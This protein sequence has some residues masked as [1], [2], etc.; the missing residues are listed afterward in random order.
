MD[1]STSFLA[2]AARFVVR[3]DSTGVRGGTG[4]FAAPGKVLT[5]AHVVSG[6]TGDSEETRTVSRVRVHWA[7][8]SS[9]G[10]VQARPTSHGGSGL[11]RYPDLAVITLLEPPRGHAWLPL[12]DALPAF[13]SGM[14]VAGFSSV[15]ERGTPQLSGTTLQFESPHMFDGHDMLKVKGGELAPGISGGP[16]LDLALGRVV[17]LVTTTRK[18]GWDMGGLALPVSAVRDCFPALWEEN[19]HPDRPDEP[20]QDLLAALRHDS[21]A[22]L[23]L[24][25]WEERKLVS[26]AEYLGMDPNALYWQAVGGLGR[27]PDAP[28]KDFTALVRECADAQPALIGE[29]H[30]LV[31]LIELVGDGK[32]QL[33]ELPHL[34]AGR[35]GQRYTRPEEPTPDEEAHVGS[36]PSI[37]VRLMPLGANRRRYLLSVWKYAGRPDDSVPVLCLDTPVTLAQARER[38]KKVLPETVRELKDHADDLVLEFSFPTGL[39]DKAMVDEWDLG[40]AWAPLGTMFV[41]VLRALDRAPVTHGNW[42]RRW[43]RLHAGADAPDPATLDWVDC[44][45]DADIGQLFATLQQAESLSVLGISYQPDNSAGRRA[46]QAA[47]YAGVP[48]AIWPRHP[49]PEHSAGRGALAAGTSSGDPRGL[50]AGDAAALCAGDRFL[51]SVGRQVSGTPL[52]ELPKLVKKLRIDARAQGQDADHCGRGLTLLW[53]DPTRPAPDADA[54]VLAGPSPERRHTGGYRT[55]PN[56]EPGEPGE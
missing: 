14:Y 49:C 33:S 34:V 9:E 38:L 39:L 4:F 44:H 50:P 1:P 28:L 19:H 42:V 54:A 35:L 43:R 51:R 3:I 23:L 26:A 25:P 16:L 2:L 11:W 45:L 12:G 7:N 48:A 32:P 37:E 36:C 27:A 6:E 20:W 53:D 56:G 5:C 24:H 41:V 29:V 15:Y 52:S 31:R 17:G 30:P 55:R 8:G 40:M 10:V 21:A 47:L 22:R 46:L 18:D 13:G